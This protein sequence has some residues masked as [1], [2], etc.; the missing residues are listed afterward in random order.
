MPHFV[1]GRVPVPDFDAAALREKAQEALL[2]YEAEDTAW[3]IVGQHVPDLA[4]ALLDALDLIGSLTRD[5]DDLGFLVDSLR[6]EVER[7]RD[8]LAATAEQH[9]I[10]AA[11][12]VVKVLGHRPEGCMWYLRAAVD[13]LPAP[14]TPPDPTP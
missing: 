1:A 9:L 8:A 3:P 10:V 12:E 13:A 5:S 11:R 6:A 14:S 4:S 2:D 7:L